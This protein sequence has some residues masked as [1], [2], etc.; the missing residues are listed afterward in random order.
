MVSLNL[1]KN[2]NAVT[3]VLILSTVFL[4]MKNWTFW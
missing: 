4:R 3:F 2:K 1:C